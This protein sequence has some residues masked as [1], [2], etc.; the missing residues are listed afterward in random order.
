MKTLCICVMG[1]TLVLLAGCRHV[2]Q[3]PIVTAFH[4]AGGG[5]IDKS[6]SDGITAFLAK[7]D[8][9]RKQL[10]PLCSQKSASASADWS[11]TDE[12]RVCTG[13]TSANFSGKVIIKS[14]G[15]PF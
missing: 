3:S 4:N 13:N 7:H 9:L 6:T 14:D 2:Q 10:T 11:T 8:D 1:A 12:G 15:V 5:D